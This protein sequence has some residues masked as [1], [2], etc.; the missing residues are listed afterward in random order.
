MKKGFFLGVL[1]LAASLHVN[2]QALMGTGFFDNW[3][4]GLNGGGITPTVHAPF[5][6]SMRGTTG[7]EIGKQVSP[8]LGLSVQSLVGINT[9]K[10]KTAFDDLNISFNGKMNLNNLFGGYNGV[11]RFFEVEAVTGVGYGHNFLSEAVG[12]ERNYITTRFGTNFNF[13]LGQSKAVTLSFKPAIVYRLDGDRPQAL[14]VNRSKI[15]LLAGVTYH[16]G[17]SNGERYMTLVEPMDPLAVEAMNAKV[18][19]L[20]GEIQVRDQALAEGATVI[21]QLQT[22]LQ[23]CQSN[24]PE[25]E[26]AMV[27]EQTQVRSLESMVTFNLGSSVIPNSQIPNVERIGIYMKNHPASTV[28]IK[29]YASPDGNLEFNQ[30]LAQARAESVKTMLMK[31][32]NISADRITAKGEGIT[33]MFSEPAWNRVSIAT[34]N[35]NNN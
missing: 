24:Q 26:V 5:W 18:N 33:D 31:K 19:Q 17:N 27:V 11:P 20:R 34:L 29:G 28:V 6:K 21:Q 4:V 3:Y 2:A 35:E 8:V 22:Q 30:K 16:F 23:N 9:T 12:D 10:S 14:N 7:F 32:Y 1:L 13:N 15:E 25:K